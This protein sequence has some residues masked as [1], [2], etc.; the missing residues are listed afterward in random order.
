MPSIARLDLIQVPTDQPAVASL[1][2]LDE[3]GSPGFNNIIRQLWGTLSS[4]DPV[5]D[6]EDKTEKKQMRSIL[7]GLQSNGR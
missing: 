7:F 5:L 6:V 1:M 2:F 3:T 4:I